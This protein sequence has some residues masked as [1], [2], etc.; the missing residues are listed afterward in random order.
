MDVKQPHGHRL[1][2]RFIPYICKGIKQPNVHGDQSCTCQALHFE[3]TDN[4]NKILPK[5]HIAM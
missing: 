5:Y 4:F 1:G 3:L 2:F